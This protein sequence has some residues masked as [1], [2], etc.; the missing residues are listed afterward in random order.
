MGPPQARPRRR[1]FAA[2][3]AQRARLE[4]PEETSTPPPPLT[5]RSDL[6]SG[7]AGLE[8]RAALSAASLM[9]APVSARL[10]YGPIERHPVVQPSPAQ[11]H[12][13]E[14]RLDALQV[15]SVFIFW[16]VTAR[17]LYCAEI[18]LRG[19]RGRLGHV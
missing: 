13:L 16:V 5:S 17:F 4:E 10:R 8:A 6:T 18:E 2:V 7:K 11:L 14:A 12:E 1:R 19:E 3:P 15:C 9:V